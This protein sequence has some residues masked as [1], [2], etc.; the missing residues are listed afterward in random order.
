MSCV[1]DGLLQMYVEGVLDA[2][3]EELLRAHLARCLG[4]RGRVARYK[5]L[6]WDLGHLPEPELPPELDQLH[7]ARLR[8]WEEEQRGA[9]QARRPARSLIPAWAGYSIGWARYAAPLDLVG[10]LLSRAGRRVLASPL[11]IARR[12]RGRR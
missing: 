1:D 4:C 11:A 6:M 8:A 9:R 3:E 7:E 10:D 5:A 12:V 2:A